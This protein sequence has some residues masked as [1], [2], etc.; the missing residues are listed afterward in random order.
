MLSIQ[1]PVDGI[2]CEYSLKILEG[3]RVFPY[4]IISIA[5]E[6]TPFTK[7]QNNLG[8]LELLQ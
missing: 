3:W 7:C 6:S 4:E 2:V 1:G 8:L 5:I